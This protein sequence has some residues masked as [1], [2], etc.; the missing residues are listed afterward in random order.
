MEAHV[1]KRKRRHTS[2][3]M[4][5][6]SLV[7]HSI[8]VL[9]LAYFAAREGLLGKQLKKIAVEMIKE[10]V[11]E[12]PKEP[13]KAKEEPPKVE[14]PK[15]A[16][17]PKSESPKPPAMEAP[18]AAPSVAAPPVV[19][20]AAIE[21]PSFVFEGGK[22]VESSSDPVTI[23]KGALE[24]A[25]FSKWER[26]SGVNDGAFVAEVEIGIDRT[27]AINGFDWKKRSG[28]SKWDESVRNAVT[29]AKT[30]ARPPPT[31]FPSRVLVRFDVQ[32]QVDSGASLR[33]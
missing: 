15:V 31:N 16:T 19:A 23:Y 30:V 3:V 9:G 2:Q 14:P 29:K 25:L 17:S 5:L 18:K 20:P 8:I 1:P 13:E 32:E 28:D 26:P 4:L 7:V 11:P 10:K 6:I 12:K 21:V 22:T 27:G 24:F 33:N